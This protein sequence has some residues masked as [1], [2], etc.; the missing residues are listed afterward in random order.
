MPVPLPGTVCQTTFTL[1]EKLKASIHYLKHTLLHHHFNFFIFYCT[2]KCPLVYCVGG[3]RAHDDDGYV[4]EDNDGRDDDSHQV[5]NS[6]PMERGDGTS[7]WKLRLPKVRSIPKLGNLARA[8][9]FQRSWSRGR[10]NSRGRDETAESQV[11]DVTTTGRLTSDPR[12]RRSRSRSRGR[13]SSF[14]RSPSKTAVKDRRN[15]V[16]TGREIDPMDL[17]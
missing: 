8:R 9:S 14:M 13:T 3:Q 5:R 10:S 17:V 12:R 2:M 16:S 15:K 1:S 4:D 6:R 11:A 7:G